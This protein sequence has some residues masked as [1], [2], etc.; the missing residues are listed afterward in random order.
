MSPFSSA[1]SA[2]VLSISSR[3]LALLS[4]RVVIR[5]SSLESSSPTFPMLTFTADMFLS[6]LSMFRLVSSIC[7]SMRLVLSFDWSRTL[8]NLLRLSPESLSS[9]I[10]FLSLSLRVF[11]V[12]E[13]TFTDSSLGMSLEKSGGLL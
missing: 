13:R 11:I 7:S 2:F 1:I 3:V 4:L 6:S 10:L 9:P 12:V 8:L 5:V